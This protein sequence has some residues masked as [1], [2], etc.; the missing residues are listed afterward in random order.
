MAT[1]GFGVRGTKVFLLE[2]GVKNSSPEDFLHLDYGCQS[3][4]ERNYHPLLSSVALA[5]RAF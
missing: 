2:V 1:E 4:N 5:L 3:I